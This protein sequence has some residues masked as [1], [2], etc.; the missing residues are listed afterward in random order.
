MSKLSHSSFGL[1][2]LKISAS[3]GRAIASYTR[4]PWFESIHRR[5]L[6]QTYLLLTVEKTQIKKKEAKNGP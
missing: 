5:N 3:V 1:N 4:G 6:L 2:T